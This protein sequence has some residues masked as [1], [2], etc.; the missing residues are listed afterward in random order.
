MTKE[1][2]NKSETDLKQE[3]RKFLNFERDTNSKKQE[4]IKTLKISRKIKETFKAISFFGYWLDERKE[5]TIRG[6]EILIKFLKEFGKRNN[7]NYLLIGLTLPEEIARITDETKNSL[8]RKKWDG[9]LKQRQRGCVLVCQY[10]K[11]PILYV[12]KSAQELFTKL[13]K[14]EKVLEIK[15][16]E[17]MVVSRKRGGLRKRQS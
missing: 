17:G 8:L 10:K 12:Q 11:K 7:I 3:L 5:T 9:I 15:V 6:N 4:I 13:F 16:L 14:K 2:K 1:I